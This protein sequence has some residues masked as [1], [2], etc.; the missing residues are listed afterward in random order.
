MLCLE[1]T[2]SSAFPQS[3]LT[4]LA[5]AAHHAAVGLRDAAGNLLGYTVQEISGGTVRWT[6]TYSYEYSLQDGYL[7]TKVTGTSSDRNRRASETLS[8]HN[9]WG[10][11][12]SLEERTNQRG[13]NQTLRSAGA[14]RL[15]SLTR[16]RADRS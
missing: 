12:T 15:F 6:D 9:G 2:V 1:R 8:S 5:S 11:R 16:F 10:R 4:R 3:T 7:E 14:G 13:F